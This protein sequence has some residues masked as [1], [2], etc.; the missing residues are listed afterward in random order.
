MTISDCLEIKTIYGS[1][2]IVS[3]LSNP[4]SSLKLWSQMKR[5]QTSDQTSDFF[6]VWCMNG[7]NMFGCLMVLFSNG[8][9][10]TRKMST[11]KAKMSGI[12]LVFPIIWLGHL[13]TKHKKSLKS[14]ML[15]FQVFG[16]QMVTVNRWLWF[17]SERHVSI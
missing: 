6:N 1:L 16:I 9:L 13:K 14:W 17:L 5:L 12:L 7:L 2:F 15:G 4:R 3:S 11:L 10:E 8:G